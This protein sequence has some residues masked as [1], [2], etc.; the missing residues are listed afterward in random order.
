MII[1]T[2]VLLF[3]YK[4]EM[5]FSYGFILFWKEVRGER[6]FFAYLEILYIIYFR[7]YLSFRR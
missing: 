6:H 1:N 2:F 7:T 3:P 4:K 5:P